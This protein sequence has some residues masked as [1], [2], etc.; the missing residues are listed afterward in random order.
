M[1][2]EGPHC[3][4]S[5]GCRRVREETFTVSGIRSCVGRAGPEA[6]CG[7]KL[8]DVANEPVLLSRGHSMTLDLAKG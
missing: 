7:L 5:T 6:G 3:R 4:G 2:E 8:A 1:A